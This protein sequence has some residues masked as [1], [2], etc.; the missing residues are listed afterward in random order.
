MVEVRA[1]DDGGVCLPGQST[2]QVWLRHVIYLLLADV[3]ATGFFKHFLEGEFAFG[4]VAGDSAQPRL[5]DR[6][7]NRLV[8]KVGSGRTKA[9]INEEKQT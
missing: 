8:A 1:D 6:A 4:V 2:D 7:D 5:D 9:K 3:A